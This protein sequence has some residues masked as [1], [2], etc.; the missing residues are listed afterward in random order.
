MSKVRT[1]QI[2][3]A[4]AA[5]AAGTS[6]L[7]SPAGATVPSFQ[8]I[9]SSAKDSVITSNCFFQVTYVSLVTGTITGKMNGQAQSTNLL[10]ALGV[11]DTAI[12]CTLSTQSGQ[13]VTISN[14]HA[15]SNAQTGVHLVTLPLSDH[16]TLT[17]VAHQDMYNHTSHTV[18][19]SV[20]T[21]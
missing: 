21:P 8:Q 7:A 11:K 5:V 19:N 2:A 16:Y 12:A 4:I 14:L 3:A 17:T 6:V 9:K 15:G 10:S 1:L 20:T 18:S 13:H